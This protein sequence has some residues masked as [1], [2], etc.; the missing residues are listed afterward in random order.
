[1]VIGAF[2]ESTVAMGTVAM[3]ATA[4]PRFMKLMVMPFT[5][6]SLRLVNHSVAIAVATGTVIAVPMAKSTRVRTSIG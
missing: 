6:G 5:I 1:M 3:K 2:Q 4:F